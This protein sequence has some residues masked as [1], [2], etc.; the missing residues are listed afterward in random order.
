MWKSAVNAGL[1][2][3]FI[4]EHVSRGDVH[5]L[6]FLLSPSV[7]TGGGESHNA[8][9]TRPSVLSTILAT[10]LRGI[11][12][13]TGAEKLQLWDMKKARFQQLRPCIRNE[14]LLVKSRLTRGR[15]NPSTAIPL[16]PVGLTRRLPFDAK[17]VCRW[18]RVSDSDDGTCRVK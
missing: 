15:R 12:D 3:C 16:M 2:A 14:K 7:G 5:Y 4:Y 9:T 1:V 6:Q 10:R 18:P 8:F 11:V 13:S 17:V